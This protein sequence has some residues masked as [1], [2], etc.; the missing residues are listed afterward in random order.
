[1]LT[2]LSRRPRQESAG[3]QITQQATPMLY[4]LSAGKT[5]AVL[6]PNKLTHRQEDSRSSPKESPSSSCFASARCP[7]MQRESHQLQRSSHRQQCSADDLLLQSKNLTLRSPASFTEENFQN[8]YIEKLKLAQKKVLKE[9]SFK[10]K[11]LQMSLPVR[12]RQKSSKRPSI[13]H[14]RSVSLSSAS[15]DAKPVPCSPSHRESL[16]SFSTDEEIRRPQK[17]QAGGRKRVTQEQKKLC[18]SEPEKLDHL[19]DKELS[20]SEGRDEITEQGAVESRRRG[21]ESRGR[22]LSSSSVSR[23]ELKQIQHSALV[24]YMERKI[25]RRPRVSQH[26]PLHR[27][28]LQKR[29]ANPKGPP[30]QT[31]NPTGSRKMQNDD[32]FC[33][34][35]S[36]QKSPDVCPPLAFAPP[37]SVS[38]R[39]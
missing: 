30:G 29:L 2:Q 21:L 32:V 3:E 35:L 33:Q 28:P 34:V 25:S 38:S 14:L 36:E 23:T 4:Y 6:H 9:T 10:R 37:R 5:T 8:D 16:E 24:E 31:S 22:A 7:E 12:L 13:E 19:M 39:C 11:D 18:Y 1:F 17:G 20:R 26:P 27:P 15:E